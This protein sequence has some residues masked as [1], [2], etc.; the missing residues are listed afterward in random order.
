MA[1]YRLT[2][3]RELV[4][5][6]LVASFDGWVD[7]GSAATMAAEQIAEGG[8]VIA[9]FDADELFD[10]RARRPTLQIIDGQL[11]ELTWPE[12]TL[13]LCGLGPRDVLVLSGPEPDYR[14]HAFGGA[15]IELA[16]RLGVAEW[17]SLGAIPAAVPHTRP[18]PIMGTASDRTRLRAGVAAG[19]EGIMRVPSAVLSMLEMAFAAAEI[20]AVGYFAQVPHYV[21]GPAP[22]AALALLDVLGGHLG[23]EIP[24]GT[25]PDQARDIRTRLDLATASDEATRAHVTRLEERADEERPASG[26]DLIAD[27]ERFLR[28]QGGGRS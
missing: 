4:A 12:L 14:W 6:V 9:T 5:P 17:I 18:V 8:T 21:T 7:A 11:R 22:A 15:V 28:D 10:Y 3:T 23:I 16:R 20:P 25:L 19:P 1:L 26:D 13:R 2:E 27:I 24:R